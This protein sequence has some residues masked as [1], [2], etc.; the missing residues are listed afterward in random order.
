MAADSGLA[1]AAVVS[2]GTAKCYCVFIRGIL[3]APAMPELLDGCP[4][5]RNA[6]SG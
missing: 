1:W 6:R 4:A 2:K 3:L 5:Y